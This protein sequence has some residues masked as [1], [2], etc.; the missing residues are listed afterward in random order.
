MEEQEHPLMTADRGFEWADKAGVVLYGLRCLIGEDSMNLALREFEDAFA[1]KKNG[2]YAGSRDLYYYLQKHTPDSLQYYL[3]DSWQKVTFY[4]NS[5]KN[6][7][8]D[9]TPGKEE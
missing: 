4:D 1:F 5:I 6:V 2:P 8:I 7:T 3:D 9:K